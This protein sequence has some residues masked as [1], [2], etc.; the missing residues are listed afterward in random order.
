MILV[1]TESLVGVVLEKYT[2]VERQI[3]E[4]CNSIIE[5]IDFVSYRINLGMQ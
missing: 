4:K 3:L 1:Y 2:A 5:L